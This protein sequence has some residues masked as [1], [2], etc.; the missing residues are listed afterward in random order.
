[1]E[2]LDQLRDFRLNAL[3]EIFFQEQMNESSLL[4]LVKHIL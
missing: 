4:N 2:C 1:M 3:F